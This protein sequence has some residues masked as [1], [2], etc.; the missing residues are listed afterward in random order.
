MRVRHLERAA[1]DGYASPLVPGLHASADAEALADE[2][3]FAAGRLAELAVAPPE[4]YADAATATDRDEGAWLALQVVLV[5]PTDDDDPFVALRAAVV[6]WAGGAVPDADALVLGP[7]APFADAAAAVRGL[8]ALRAWLE[9]SGGPMAALAGDP[10][11]TPER[12]FAR[13][14]ERLGTVSGIGRGR[15]DALE[16]VGRLGLVE[17]SADG[18]HAG[19]RDD[20]TLAAKRVFGIGDPLLLDRRAL[21]LAEEAEL[22]IAALD[23][24]LANVGRPA[25][26]PRMT[27]G[28]SGDAAD[29]AARESAAAALGL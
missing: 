13:I 9:R 4:L 20:A 11:W 21:E 27:M 5:G 2:L 26:T 8:A 1:E 28:A 22:P 15:Y 24:A 25:G 3:G 16:V 19:D 23:L 7:R 6:P 12:R 18:L 14:F 17:V 10:S 29:E